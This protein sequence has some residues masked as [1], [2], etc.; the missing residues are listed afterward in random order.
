MTTRIVPLL[1]VA[2]GALACSG[3]I[4]EDQQ[5]AVLRTLDR[6]LS[7]GLQ[8]FITR[9]RADKLPSPQIHSQWYV[10]E[11]GQVPAGRLA[12]EQQK[13]QFGRSLLEVLDRTSGEI[14]AMQDSASRERIAMVLLDL[15]D[16]ISEQPGY[17]NMFIFER[18]QDMAT[19]PLAHLVAD[20][21]YP[22]SKLDA[23]TARLRTFEDF[24]RMAPDAL[25]SELPKPLFVA[26]QGKTLKEV[27]E[28]L[29][30]AYGGGRTRVREWVKANL[31]RW[32]IPEGKG[33]REALPAEMRFFCDDDMPIS[34]GTTLEWW[35]VKFHSR[36]V[37]GLGGGNA[38]AVR[39]F[40]LFRKKVGAFPTQPPSWWKPGDA[41]FDTPIKAA[42]DQAWEPYRKDL[43]PV[44]GTAANVY[45][46]VTNNTYY[47][48]DSQ[49]RRLREA[50]RRPGPGAHVP[51]QFAPPGGA[52]ITTRPW[53]TS[54]WL[55]GTTT[56]ASQPASRLAT[57]PATVPNIEPS[58][59]RQGE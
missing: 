34:F 20:L 37:L 46:A 31:A 52:P 35:D 44:Y 22:E 57:Q 15:G 53:R 17:G 56:P 49:Y 38:N 39:S 12:F 33:V 29:M 47:D 10:G 51:P 55:Y 16:W 59:T 6:E 2:I 9:A 25:N 54:A 43:G 32:T 24:A 7:L 11:S 19:V 28:P 13:R 23:L 26:G 36:L 3:A 18:C 40:L 1:V 41:L 21:T 4:Y 42:F 30:R 5:A 58:E 14:L 50:G 27:Q 8:A 48:R 45:I